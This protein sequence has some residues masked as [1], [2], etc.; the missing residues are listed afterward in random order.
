[1]LLYTAGFK[2]ISLLS[3]RLCWKVMDRLQHPAI[4]SLQESLSR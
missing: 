3:G 1:M 4:P 2:L